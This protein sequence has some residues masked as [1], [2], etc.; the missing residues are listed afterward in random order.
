MLDDDSLKGIPKLEKLLLN[1]NVI[2][3]IK[4]ELFAGQASFVKLSPQNNKLTSLEA[5]AFGSLSSLQYL[6]I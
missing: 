4:R 6:N 3:E 5:H 2:R 1:D